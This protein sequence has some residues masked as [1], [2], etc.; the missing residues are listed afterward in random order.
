MR[1]FIVFKLSAEVIVAGV[2]Q[3]QNIAGKVKGLLIVWSL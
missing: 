2:F 1:G 3:K